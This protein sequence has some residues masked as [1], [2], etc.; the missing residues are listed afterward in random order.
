MFSA[1]EHLCQHEQPL[2]IHFNFFKL[3][4]F[5]NIH[6]LRLIQKNSVIFYEYFVI[7]I[8]LATI[9]FSSEYY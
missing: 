6:N 8:L 7:A 2:S 9:D 4:Q 3:M 5:Q 1:I